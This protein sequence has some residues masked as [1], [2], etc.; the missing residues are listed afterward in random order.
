MNLFSLKSTLVCALLSPLL[1]SAAEPDHAELPV[2]E[3][4]AGIGALALPDYIGADEEQFYAAPIPWFV[5]RG[6]RFR[7][8]RSGLQGL[9]Y[10]GD[11]VRLDLSF[12][13]SVPVDSDDNAVRRGMADLDPGFEVGPSLN[14]DLLQQ[15]SHRLQALLRAR[16][17]M[18]LDGIR[19]HYQG[20]IFNPVLEWSVLQSA[21]VE[22]R[23][24]SRI[25]YGNSGYHDFF[26]GVDPQFATPTRPAYRAE[27]GYGGVAA[28]VSVNAD[29]DRDWQLVSSLSWRDIHGS[30]FDDSP[31]VK[32]QHGIFFNVFLI[33]T[34]Y[35]SGRTTG[36]YPE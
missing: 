35:R 10:S 17:L 29:L 12:S 8:D 6:K 15:D 14:I 7:A 20:W 34:F 21:A 9:F 27:S 22:W 25:Y 18:S 33:R 30:E 4:G 1:L 2:F 24:S 31:L 19:S 11:G 28:R 13:G 5:Y 3:V 32:R 26:Y 36:D 16:A 23:F